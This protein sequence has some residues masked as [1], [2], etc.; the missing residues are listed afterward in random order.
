M[1]IRPLIAFCLLA[2]LAAAEPVALRGLDLSPGQ[3]TPR[4]PAL[5][6][7]AAASERAGAV[8]FTVQPGAG[9]WTVVDGPVLTVPARGK[10]CRDRVFSLR[11]QARAE[12]AEGYCLQVRLRQG[13]SGA[14]WTRNLAPHALWETTAELTAGERWRQWAPLEGASS[15]GAGCEALGLEVWLKV[16]RG[17]ATSVILAGVELDERFTIAHRI[18]TAPAAAGNIV[19]AASGSLLVE[20]ADPERLAACRVALSDEEGRALGKVEGP[21]GS[22]TLAVALPG[23]GFYAVEASADYRDAPAIATRTT[24]AVVGEPLP[25]AVRKASRFGSMRVWG[26]GEL[27]SRSGANWDWSIGGIDLAGYQRA[28][29]GAITPPANARPIRLPAD[30]RTVMTFNQFPKWLHGQSGSG[31]FPPKDWGELE[32]LAEAF[33]RANPDLAHFC[34]FNEP[35][36]HWRGSAEEFVRFHQAIAAGVRRGNPAMKIYGPCMY[37]LRLDDL[38]KYAALGLLDALDGIVMHAYVNGTAPEG[39]FMDKVGAFTAWL[40]EQGRGEWPVYIT[41]YGWCSGVGDWQKTISEGERLRF[42]SRSLALMA[43]EA[44]D[45]IAYF[46]F[47][48]CDNLDKPGYSLL[49]RDHTPTPTYVAFVTSLQWLSWTRRGD[50][51]WFRLSPDLNLA[52]F[53]DGTQAVAAAWSAGAP[54]QVRLPAAPARCQD[55]MGRARAADGDRLAVDGLPVFGALP[56]DRA[57]RDMAT[58]PGVVAAPGGELALPWTPFLAAPEF[59]CAAGK[60]RVSPTARPGE[61]LIIGRAGAAWQALPVTVPAPLELVR[62]ER[63]L[64]ADAASL[65]V[66]AS[67]RSPV[68]GRPEAVLSVALEGGARLQAATRLEAGAEAPLAVTIP[69]LRPGRRLRG[70]IELALRG[71]TPWTITRP[72]DQT[73]LVAP[74]IAGDK[75]DWNAVPVVEFADWGP[76]PG[77]VADDDCWA[78]MRAAVSARGFHLLVEV[79]DDV[80]WQGSNA[81]G[82]WQEDSLQVAFDVDADRPWQANNVG[83]GFNGHR[84]TEFGLGMASRG[85]PAVAW[86]YRADA[87]DLRAGVAEPR[88][89]LRIERQGTLTRYEA[90]FPWPALG[91]ADAPANGP[92]LGFALLVNDADKQGGR[93]GLRLGDGINGPKDPEL[94]PRLLVQP[95]G[96]P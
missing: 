69:G 28:A 65:A 60:A 23:R 30:H 75:P 62:L 38:K 32:R 74:R 34:P 84:I 45:A 4:E 83:N 92:G 77:A 16:P 91:R 10:F 33:A 21:A 2:G 15:A 19:F 54:G 26:S 37:S 49:Y 85:G 73:V 12:V 82:M 18:A 36:A 59:A 66:A 94:F 43:T 56:S 67:V 63:T 96:T 80:F 31:L 27:W 35:D 41:E 39:E 81:A 70:S 44:V 71:D 52:L 48:H 61:Y 95:Q 79:T 53:D 6:A 29:D 20:F 51:R 1:S 58:L 22:A 86:R 50:G 42:A 90:L 57:F 11:A 40:K 5:A 47:M 17:A 3:W 7:V 76:W 25:A 87:P 9:E 64:A 93:H 88:V 24:A 46:C 14:H 89:E 13:R 68:A 8:R 78:Q 72:L 55:A